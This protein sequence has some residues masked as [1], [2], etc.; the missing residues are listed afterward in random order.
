MRCRYPPA[1][2][3]K[4]DI[5]LRTKLQPWRKIFWLFWA[6]GSRIPGVY[7]YHHGP[8]YFAGFCAVLTAVMEFP[9]CDSFGTLFL[10][11]SNS[12]FS[13]STLT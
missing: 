10:C 3:R 1:S 4:L 11:F 5:V 6:L 8:W 12:L 9:V 7:T 2:W 13:P